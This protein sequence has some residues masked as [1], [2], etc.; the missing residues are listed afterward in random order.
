MTFNGRKSVRK[1]FYRLLNARK[2]MD[3]IYCS[4]GLLQLSEFHPELN[5]CIFE[6]SEAMKCIETA[7]KDSRRG[8]R[9]KHN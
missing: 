1:A 7:W 4:S 8:N 5:E 3:T 9:W 6:V 2:K